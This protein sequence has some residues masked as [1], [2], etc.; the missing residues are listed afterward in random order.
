VKEHVN[1]MNTGK[2]PKQIL[3]YQVRGQRWVRC[4]RKDGRK[5]WA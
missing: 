4:P 3:Y 2:I 5:I 1:R